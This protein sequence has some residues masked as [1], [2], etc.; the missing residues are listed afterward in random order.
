MDKE[1][2]IEMILNE[3]REMTLEEIDALEYA[4][5]CIKRMRGE[6]EK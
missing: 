3:A 1:Q 2:I 4:I 6:E 5:F